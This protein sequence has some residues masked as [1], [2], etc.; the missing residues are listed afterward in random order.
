MKAQLVANGRDHDRDIYPDHS[1]LTAAIHSVF[2]VLGLVLGNLNR[3]TPM[4]LDAKRAFEQSPMKGPPVFM[5]IYPLLK[6]HTVEMY[7]KYSEYIQVMG[8]L[9]TELLKSNVGMSTS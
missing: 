6:K 7:P 2:T 4:K 8:V 3:L 5:K 1:S 9:V